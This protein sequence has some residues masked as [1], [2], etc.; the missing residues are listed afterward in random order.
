M[1][2]LD[3]LSSFEFENVIDEVAQNLGYVNGGS[4]DKDGRQ[5]LERRGREGTT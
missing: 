5:G 4:I 2:I 3:D 1:A